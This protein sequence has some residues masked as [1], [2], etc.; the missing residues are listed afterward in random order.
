MC[1]TP[2][3]CFIQI[4]ICALRAANS[5]NYI[6][7]SCRTGT[8]VMGYSPAFGRI[9]LYSDNGMIFFRRVGV[10]LLLT[11]RDALLYHFYSFF[12]ELFKKCLIFGFTF[13]TFIGILQSRN[14]VKKTAGLVNN[15]DLLSRQV[16][17]NGLKTELI[18]LINVQGPRGRTSFLYNF[19]VRLL[20]LIESRRLDSTNNFI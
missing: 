15:I 14:N 19:I 18:K 20:F 16:V 7:Y 5:V 12:F 17:K 9:P 1:T 11:Y 10:R 8:W 4:W 6:D 2:Y 13:Y 3:S